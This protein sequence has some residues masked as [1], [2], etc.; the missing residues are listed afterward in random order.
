M[1]FVDGLPR[2]AP[3]R[4]PRLRLSTRGGVDDSGEGSGE[5][6]VPRSG[7]VCCALLVVVDVGGVGFPLRSA[8]RRSVLGLTSCCL[9]VESSRR[10]L[11][12]RR[13]SVG[14]RCV[15]AVL[16]S[17][18]VLMEFGALPFR[19]RLVPVDLRGG[20]LR[21]LLSIGN[22]RSCADRSC[23]R[24]DARLLVTRGSGGSTVSNAAKGFGFGIGMLLVVGLEVLETRWCDLEVLR[25]FRSGVVGS[26]LES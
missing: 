21:V 26:I 16:E 20:K 17:L 22:W 3:R 5:E 4:A 2:V 13:I 8:L 14:L 23:E 19:F 24:R 7:G 11:V 15:E 12:D 9:G 1:S 10:C 25:H 18:R 6:C